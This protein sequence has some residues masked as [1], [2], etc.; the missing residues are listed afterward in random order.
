MPKPASKNNNDIYK[1]IADL[2][3]K[4]SHKNNLPQDKEGR[5]GKRLSILQNTLIGVGIGFVISITITCFFTF[6]YKSTPSELLVLNTVLGSTL[7]T[8][9]GV[10][11]G[12]SID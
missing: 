1:E 3:E 8:I 4:I 9:I 6:F 11:A 10:I 2:K 5:K 12:T 7:T